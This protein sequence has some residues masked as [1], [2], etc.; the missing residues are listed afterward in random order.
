MPRNPVASEKRK[1]TAP[2]NQR[3]MSAT[4]RMADPKRKASHLEKGQGETMKA[5]THQSTPN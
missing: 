3:K 1:S 4:T 5:P 2:S